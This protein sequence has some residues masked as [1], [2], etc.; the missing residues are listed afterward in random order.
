MTLRDTL[1]PAEYWVAQITELYEVFEEYRQDVDDPSRGFPEKLGDSYSMSKLSFEQVSALYSQGADLAVC[2]DQARRLLI[3]VYP[4]FVETARQKPETAKS[5]YAGGFDFR[6]R[7]LALAVLAKLSSDEAIPLVE[8]LDFWPERD[9]LWE[10]FIVHLGHG[11]GRDTV[12]T[13]VWPEA[14]ENLLESF[15]PDLNANARQA[16]LLQ[17]EKGWLK[18]MRSSTNPFYSNHNNRHNTYVGYWNFEAAAVVV[19]LGIDDIVVEGSKTYPKDWA[20][21]AR[22]AS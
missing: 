7:Y 9:A 4:K 8:A 16:P 19:M 10:K 17:F 20:D 5:G 21:W 1:K 12:T 15:D 11:E 18:Q 14:Y 13:L 6:T 22:R 2:A 3:D